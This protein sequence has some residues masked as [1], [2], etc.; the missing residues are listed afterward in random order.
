MIWHPLGRVYPSTS[1]IKILDLLLFAEL[2]TFFTYYLPIKY[3]VFPKVKI[4]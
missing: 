4:V 1:S 2:L 3:E